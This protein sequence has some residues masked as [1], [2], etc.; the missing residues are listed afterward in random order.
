MTK[1]CICCKQA[2]ELPNSFFFRQSRNADGFR[3]D[4]I[5]CFNKKYRPNWTPKP[6]LHKTRKQINAETYQR[7]KSN[8]SLRIAQICRIRTGLALKNGFYKKEKTFDL[9]GCSPNFLKQYIESK[10]QEGMTWENYGRFGWHI[11]HIKPCVRFDLS[12]PKERAKCFHYTNLQPLWWRD[13]VRFK[14]KEK[15]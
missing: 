11:D 3:S 5:E 8:P 2:K 14:D 12:K 1:I 15:I 9:I 6:K 13:N 7:R 4:C 10:F